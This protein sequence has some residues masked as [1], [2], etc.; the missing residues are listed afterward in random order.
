MILR[1]STKSVGI[2]VLFVVI[3]AVLGGIL[4]EL[5][6]EITAL[7]GIVPYLVQT[8]SILDLS[9]VHINLYVIQLSFG[10]VFAPNLMSIF[11]VLLA[12]FL[13]RKY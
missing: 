5:M 4:G 8:Y 11:G 2:C 6:K 1:G 12:V 13:F 7:N 9:P 3:G 10:L